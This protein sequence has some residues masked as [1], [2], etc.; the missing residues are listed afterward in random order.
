MPSEHFVVR[1]SSGC[2]FIVG[3]SL[4]IERTRLIRSE[5]GSSPSSVVS[6][7]TSRS[8]GEEWRERDDLEVERSALLGGDRWTVLR[9]C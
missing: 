9:T 5:K 4:Y 2:N 3:W 1:V 8:S 6:E 7:D